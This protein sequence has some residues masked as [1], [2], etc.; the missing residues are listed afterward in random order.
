MRTQ[1]KMPQRAPSQTAQFMHMGARILAVLFL[2][3]IIHES[4]LPVASTHSA[5]HFDKLMH[6]AA[7]GA[8]AAMYKF[9]WPSLKPIALALGL[10]A[11]GGVVEIAQG[12]MAAGRTASFADGVANSLGVILGI[13][14]AIIILRIVR[15]GD[16][17]SNR[18]SFRL[19][20][21]K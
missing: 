11:V 2:V 6:L 18:D 9:G 16:G 19:A 7:Y 5:T 1:K 21:E 12:V 20:P 3:V 10:I 8:L 14:F 17:V 13:A 15:R 4:L